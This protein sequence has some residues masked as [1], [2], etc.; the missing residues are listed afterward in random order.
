MAK[1]YQGICLLVLLGCIGVQA[2]TIESQSTLE[3]EAALEALLQQCNEQCIPQTSSISWIDSGRGIHIRVYKS[4][5][6]VV[7]ERCWDGN[8]WFTGSFSQPG[9]QSSAVAWQDGG[10]LH[11]RLYISYASNIQEYTCDPQ[12]CW[13]KGAF[14]FPGSSSSATIWTTPQ[15]GIRVYV[16]TDSGITEKCWDGSGWYTGAYS[17]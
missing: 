3:A 17:Y 11:V 5:N 6:N 4:I 7:T 8:G 9:S 16:N 2:V 1:N 10:N 12:S 13:A 15:L 14:S